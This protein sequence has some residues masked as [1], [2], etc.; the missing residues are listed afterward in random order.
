MVERERLVLEKQQHED[1]EDGQREELLNHLE[2]PE[3]E[4]TAIL[5]EADTVGGHHKAVLDQSDAPTEKDDH[6]QRELTEPSG[7]LQFQV[8]VPR[9]RHEHVRTNQQQKCVNTFHIFIII[10][11]VIGWERAP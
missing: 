6:R 4:G 5:D 9:K 1:G 3:V 2:L 7:A 8:T 10:L 11:I